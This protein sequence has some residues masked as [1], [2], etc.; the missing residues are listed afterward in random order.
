MAIVGVWTDWRQ[1]A[2]PLRVPSS[3]PEDTERLPF[4]TALAYGSFTF[5]AIALVACVL[6]GRLGG[7]RMATQALP[8]RK[9][10]PRSEEHKT[11]TR[12]TSERTERGREKSEGTTRPNAWRFD[13]RLKNRTS[14]ELGCWILVFARLC[15]LFAT[16]KRSCQT[17]SYDCT[18]R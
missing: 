4:S 3:R 11:R 14:L 15:V 16:V 17:N 9:E 13:E 5:F 2:T 8:K 10:P 18:C 1:I 12:R 6:G 7:R